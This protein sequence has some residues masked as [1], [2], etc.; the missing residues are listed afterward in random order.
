MNGPRSTTLPAAIVLWF[1][2]A[3]AALI[4]CR[5]ETAPPRFP[6]QV[7]LTGIP[8]GAPGKPECLN[9]VSCHSVAVND[10]NH[11]MPEAAVCDR[12]HKDAH[13]TRAVL[14]VT[15]VR[16]SGT[17]TIDHDQHLALPQIQGQCVPCHAGVVDTKRPSLPPMS[18]CFGCHEHEEQW[19][20]GECTP[21]HDPVALRQT[22][23]VTFLKHDTAF[24]R[25][26]GE[27]MAQR[28]D[29]VICQNCHT[30]S[31][32]QQCHDVTQDLT[33]EARR[34]EAIESG[35]VH[36]GDFM[37]RHAIE[38]RSEPSRCLSCHTVETC[39]SCHV[40]RGVS[41]NV[42]NPQ[43]PHPIGWI[44]SDTSSPNFHGAAA[45]RD[46]VACAGCHEAGPA[47][48]CIRCHKVG[49]YGGSPHPRGWKSSQSM[50]SEMCRYC[51]G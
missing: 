37:V 27:V 42:A 28:Q 41:A 43:N 30:Q 10:T 1:T 33:V 39:D 5:S 45:R 12:C 2:V 4:A 50:S 49:A 44:G 22:M 23:P 40:A 38:A 32:C 24:L 46:I 13:E 51:H 19:Q 17:I 6:H 29:A 20:R 15:P 9:C 26:H 21:C 7:H 25:H 48:N 8:C 14:A 11:R 31:Q 35:Q 34:P 36:R 47:T 3:F 18:Q 16:V